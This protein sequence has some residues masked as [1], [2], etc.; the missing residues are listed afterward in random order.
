M[1]VGSRRFSAWSCMM[2]TASIAHHNTKT[3]KRGVGVV[4]HRRGVTAVA[5]L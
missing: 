2:R 1:T 3:R 5:R 4:A